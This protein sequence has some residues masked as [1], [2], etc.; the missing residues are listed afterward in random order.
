MKITNYNTDDPKDGLCFW[1]SRRK[2]HPYQ[3][4]KDIILYGQ[5]NN[6]VLH[7]C[8]ENMG[9]KLRFANGPRNKPFYSI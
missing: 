4:L 8:V 6:Q 7:V 9:E 2:P 3:S 1:C 5:P